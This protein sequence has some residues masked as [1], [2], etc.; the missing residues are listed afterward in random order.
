MTTGF[1]IPKNV[2]R[3]FVLVDVE[4]GEEDTVME[5]LIKFPETTEVHLIAGKHDILLCIDIE[6]KILEESLEKGL[7]FIKGKIRPLPGVIDTDTLT[8]G[9]SFIRRAP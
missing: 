3:F 7:K 8:V 5:R 9:K 2:Q 1:V 4:P 6:R